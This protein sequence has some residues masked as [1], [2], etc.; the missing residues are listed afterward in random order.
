MVSLLSS[1]SFLPHQ[2]KF[3]INQYHPLSRQSGSVAIGSYR[4]HPR[5]DWTLP[6]K[7]AIH[8]MSKPMVYLGSLKRSQIRAVFRL[9]VFCFL[10]WHD[11]LRDLGSTYPN[12][13]KQI[14]FFDC[15]TESFIMTHMAGIA[16]I[17]WKVLRQGSVGRRT[18]LVNWGWNKTGTGSSDVAA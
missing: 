17:S 10:I 6:W 14:I 4:K 15:K 1:L 9:V 5:G 13:F 8:H 3:K 2:N 12:C 18:V 7:Y 11:I 16:G